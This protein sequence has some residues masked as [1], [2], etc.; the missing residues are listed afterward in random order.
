MMKD[1]NDETI[2]DWRRCAVPGDARPSK[3]TTNGLTSGS[4]ASTPPRLATPP[5][6]PKPTLEP[7][8]PG[9]SAISSSSGTSNSNTSGVPAP[10]Q[11]SHAT[12]GEI[13]EHF[14]R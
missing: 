8:Q 4:L 14:G 7:K 12:G 5:A 1:V 11:H 3:L 13:A 6:K 9:V 10:T 2:P